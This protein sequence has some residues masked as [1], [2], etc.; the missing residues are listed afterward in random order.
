M[1]QGV[2]GEGVRPINSYPSVLPSIF[3]YRPRQTHTQTH[4]RISLEAEGMRVPNQSMHDG[5]NP[6]ETIVY[7]KKGAR[8]IEG[9]RWQP[10]ANAADFPT[11]S[12]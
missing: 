11:Q 3:F 2:G 12:I 4:T 9:S 1:T 8:N 10:R 6:V 5:V 7:R